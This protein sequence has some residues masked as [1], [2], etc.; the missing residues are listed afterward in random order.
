MKTSF[1]KAFKLFFGIVF[2]FLIFICGWIYN[3][4]N[5]GDKQEFK[6]GSKQNFA[7]IT[8]PSHSS[9]RIRSSARKKLRDPTSML[10]RRR[11]VRK[12]SSPA[13]LEESMKKVHKKLKDTIANTQNSPANGLLGLPRH[14]GIK[15]RNP[16][17]QKA[18]NDLLARVPV[19]TVLH[20]DNF[21]G[22]LRQLRGNLGVLVKD[23]SSYNDARKDLNFSEMTYTLL[24]ELAPAMR[25]QDSAEEFTIERTTEDD[26]GMTHIVLRQSYEEQPVWG[27]Q[28][29]VHFDR[30]QNPLEVNGLYIPGLQLQELKEQISETE[31]IILAKKSLKM[32]GVGMAPIK[33]QRLIFWDLHRAPVQSYRVDLVPSIA[34]EWQ[35]FVAIADGRVLHKYN[36]IQ[37]E[38]VTVNVPDLNGVQQ[39]ISVWKDGN[40]YYAI[41]TT[42][43]FYDSN[44]LPPDPQNTQG[45]IFSIDAQNTLEPNPQN[46]FFVTSNN[47][48]TWDP[49]A[50]SVLQN[51]DIVQKYFQ[52]SF[53]RASI[54]DN[55]MN[56]FGC[57]HVGQNFDNAYWSGN[58]QM[59]FFGDGSNQ[60]GGFSSL[61]G[62]L[63]VTAHELVHGIIQFTAGLIYE[64]QSGAINE[65]I[66]DFFG[67]MVDR[68]D[69]LIGD[70]I[71]VGRAGL[72]DMEN[73]GNPNVLSEQPSTMTEYRN[74]PN[75]PQG[76]HGG[77]HINSGILNRMTFLLAAGP[78][79]IGRQKT[80]QII[81]RALTSYLLERSQFIDYR[82]AA[83][84]A[85][86]DLYGVDSLEVEAVAQAFD[87]VKIVD[88]GSGSR[89]S[90]G[91]P[92][93]GAEKIIFVEAEP[94]T[95]NPFS[96]DYRYNLVLNDGNN[97]SL[98]TDLFVLDTRPAISG[99]G[100]FILFVDAF[101]NL[102]FTDGTS[103]ELIAESSA[104]VFSSIAMSKDSR[105]VAFTTFNDDSTIFLLDLEST[106]DPAVVIELS[107]PQPDGEPAI[108]DFADILAFNFQGDLLVFDALSTIN[109]ASQATISV[110]GLYS[111]RLADRTL[112]QLV[113]GD[114]NT[115]LANPIFSHTLNG[116]LLADSIRTENNGENSIG[117]VALD[118]ITGEEDR[119]LQNLDFTGRSS[120]RGDDDSALFRF[121]LP[122][123]N[124]F[125]L[126]SVGFGANKFSLDLDSREIIR[127]NSIPIS[128]SFGFREGDY[129]Q[130]KGKIDA[131][132]KIAFGETDIGSMQ[133]RQLTLVNTGNGDL[134]LFSLSTT[135][136]E[137]DSFR[138]NGLDRILGPQESYTFNV[139]FSPTRSGPL[140]AFLEIGSTDIDSPSVSV[141]LEGVGLAPNQ[142]PSITILEPAHNATFTLKV[143]ASIEIK[144]MAE[145]SDGT[146]ALVEFFVND[147]TIGE[148]AIS[149]FGFS[150][151]E[152]PAGTFQLTA[153]V[154]DNEGLK[155]N[156][157]LVTFTIIPTV[158]VDLDLDNLDDDW[159]MVHFQGLHFSA[160][161]D[162]D[163]DGLSNLQ[164]FTS[165]QDPFGYSLELAEGWNLK[166]L[167]LLPENASISSIFQGKIIASVWTWDNAEKRFKIATFMESTRGYWIFAHQEYRNR[168]AVLIE[169]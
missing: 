24:S 107:I 142:P 138:I 166:S 159:E 151:G 49:A 41:D 115:Q 88:G 111:L 110:W 60:P 139:D 106:V 155:G 121:F 23:S 51:F 133:T 78:S 119:L 64:N 1:P 55:G 162:P 116:H 7:S 113:P 66:A 152:V 33:A 69:W 67:A 93:S 161:D 37:H 156:S 100:T 72:R 2:L 63:D 3:Q 137:P 112:Q 56:I 15:V 123:A 130:R 43:T 5:S 99:D 108:L 30:E 126:V 13:D 134:E 131:P 163:K 9:S 125:E 73:P 71:A 82:R 92:T 129:V 135:G 168:N 52:E 127:S 140:S 34:E 22:S 148:S 18:V 50:V 85:A 98:L 79:G 145:D 11:S 65:H 83:L 160:E 62:S 70:E 31:A 38:S 153:R 8:P 165:G 141:E 4:K 16:E 136:N 167:G 117:M 158:E 101:F 29:T 90:P 36:T 76:D 6:E 150:W 17:Q 146:I 46:L 157:E 68:D 103:E 59:M 48:N 58:R 32:S 47:P 20:M 44:S 25:I 77:V 154:T 12:C 124:E 109:F 122:T 96:E 74:L 118:Y 54:N 169:L 128:Y 164:E 147:T 91:T 94:G 19:D 42:T 149:P 40:T 75:T 28:I 97:L 61:A 10:A 26:L 132:D 84:S 143:P 45:A 27:S 95:F 114:P 57:I 81:Y 87:D 104:F 39:N 89:P 120:Y 105:F 35:I 14:R 86:E 80:E 102:W 21:T 53:N 144:V